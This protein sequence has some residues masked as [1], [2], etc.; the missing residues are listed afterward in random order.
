MIPT[1]RPARPADIQSVLTLWIESDAEPPHTDDAEFLHALMA[2]DPE[3]LVVAED[4]TDI[5]GSVIA[6][7]DGWRGSILRLVVSPTHRRQGLAVR[8]LAHAETRLSTVGAVRLQAI[9]VETDPVAVGFWTATGWEQQVE[10]LRF[11]NG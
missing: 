4:G 7:W 10:R 3:A 2:E 6:A 5:V 11:V 9:V 1:I 8:L